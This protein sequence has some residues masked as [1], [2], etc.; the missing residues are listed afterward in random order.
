MILKV[1]FQVLGLVL[2]F[3]CALAQ[4]QDARPQTLAF[5]CMACHGPGGESRGDIP[6]L[7]G[8]SYEKFKKGLLEFKQDR[9]PATIMNR[10]AKGYS[11][12][13]I[14]VLARYFSALPAGGQ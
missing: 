7:T 6:S 5:P 2:V 11:D 3:G 13:E 8:I 9:R 4:A 14:E 10:I 12:Q 1:W